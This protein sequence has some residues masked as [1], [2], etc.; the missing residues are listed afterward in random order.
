[1]E[2]ENMEEGTPKGIYNTMHS[3]KEWRRK[4]TY[5]IS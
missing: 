2:G 3:K 1:V 4:T 5:H